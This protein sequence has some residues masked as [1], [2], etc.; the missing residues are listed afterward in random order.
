M[1]AMIKFQIV[2]PISMNSSVIS[3]SSHI[4]STFSRK[5]ERSDLPAETPVCPTWII[6]LR[7]KNVQ[8]QFLFSY[9]FFNE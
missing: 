1:T 5:H 4:N 3:I 7:D 8:S 2:L 9:N 6:Q